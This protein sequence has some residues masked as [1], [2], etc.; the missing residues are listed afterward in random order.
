MAIIKVQLK[1]VRTKVNIFLC[2]ERAGHE[3]WCMEHLTD[4][5]ILKHVAVIYKQ[6]TKWRV[7]IKNL[8]NLSWDSTQPG[9]PVKILSKQLPA[10][11]LISMW[12]R[13][14]S[15]LRVETGL[16]SVSSKQGNRNIR[17]TREHIDLGTAAPDRLSDSRL[18]ETTRYSVQVIS[19]S[20]TFRE[21]KYKN[22]NESIPAI[23][24]QF[25]VFR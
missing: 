4:P 8:A 18:V 10:D 14:H 13:E 24:S 15:R 7:N 12:A 16:R 3:V 6:K 2:F 5:R 19:S 9:L 1:Q 17:D 22:T 25:L 23:A 21:K 20:T 11:H